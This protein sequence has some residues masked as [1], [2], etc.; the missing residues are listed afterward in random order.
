MGLLDLPLELLDQIITLTLPSGIENFALA[1]KVVYTRAASQIQRH[2]SL[3]RQWNH[4]IITRENSLQTLYDL[5]QEPLVAKYITSPT[6]WGEEEP[7]DYGG[8]PPLDSAESKVIERTVKESGYLQVAGVD[9]DDWFDKMEERMHETRVRDGHDGG[10]LYTAVSLLTQL[11]NLKSLALWP[12]WADA[13]LNNPPSH[14]DSNLLAAVLNALVQRANQD[15]TALAPLAQLEVILPFMRQG[16]DERA[17]LQVLEPFLRLK[18]LRELYAVSCLAVDDGYT[19][20]PFQWTTADSVSQLR[21]IELAYCCLDADGIST[22]VSRTPCLEVFRYS[23]ETKWH[24]CQHDWNPGAFIEALARHCSET[25][26]DFSLTVDELFGE[27]ENGASTFLSFKRLLDLEVDVLIFRGPPLE[28]GQRRGEV[29]IGPAPGQRDW[30]EVDIPC[31]GS[32]LPPSIHRVTINSDFPDPDKQALEALLKNLKQQRAERLTSLEFILVRDA[33]DARP[34]CERA[35]A[36][37]EVF[38]AGSIGKTM[39]PAWKRAFA[40]RVGGIEFT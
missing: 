40:Q 7:D 34:F 29:A 36:E 12:G 25:I 14:D 6:L 15:T 32:M 16:Y 11:P 31:V 9:A 1:S 19:G 23:H 35:G 28:S 30:A 10:L 8:P 39:R 2:N 22:L 26:I 33:E 3:K 18:S 13:P 24:G 5:S 21:R 4:A 38:D 27:I 20:I 17:G 37:L